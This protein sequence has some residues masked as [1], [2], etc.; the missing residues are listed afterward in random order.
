MATRQ[1]DVQPALNPGEAAL[2]DEHL[3]ESMRGCRAAVFAE[4][5]SA[6][7][8]AIYNLCRRILGSPEDAQDVTQEVFIKAY[9]QL[10]GCDAGFR[11]EPWLYRVAV[12]ACYDLLRARKVLEPLPDEVDGP[13][14][15]GYERA[16]LGLLLE[17]TLAGLSVRHRTVVLLKDVHGLSHAEIADV[18]GVSR[19]ATETLLSRARR[20]FRAG[21]TAL[22]R[23]E[24][25]HACEL[26]RQA[27]VDS[28]GGGLSARQRRRISAHAKTCPD[29]RDT[30]A[31]WGLGALG[32][33]AFLHAAPLPAALATPPFAAAV[34]AAGAAGAAGGAA[35]GSVG[36]AGAAAGTGAG[37]AGAAG[38]GSVGA[39]AGAGSVGAAGAAA[40][41]SGGAAA[42]VAGGTT[43][44]AAALAAGA[45][46]KIAIVAVAA[47]LT[48]AGGLTLQH[49]KS[50]PRHAGVSAAAASHAG[51]AGSAAQNR[52]AASARSLGHGAAVALARHHRKAA[53]H[54]H[55]AR[56][57]AHSR[58]G[59][60]AGHSK[61]TARQ[62]G[63]T[64]TA[65]RG[66]S[67]A[68]RPHTA[69]A[70]APSASQNHSSS[71]HSPATPAGTHQGKSSPRTGQ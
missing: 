32:L 41:A 66:A 45:A 51:P 19:N 11:A 64:S 70:A 67:S 9:R 3:P 33:A 55:A 71:A 69:G 68:T 50:A 29:C 40:G 30:V 39:A 10:A 26:A 35:A 59:A 27:V 13:Q 36:A 34:A 58:A 63:K 16:E 7:A 37:S 38:A 15:D 24:P 17:Q 61:A 14:V 2:G 1:A 4:L 42:G 18:L 47:T 46:V 28:V 65:A 49:V 62:R 52:G 23:S 12:N 20:A 21:Y 53:A 5:Y 8:S 60:A 57:A 6:Q 54:K 44:G 31:T 22:A 56:A 25:R 48:V 43:A